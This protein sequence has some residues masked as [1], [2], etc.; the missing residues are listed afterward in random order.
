MRDVKIM[1]SKNQKKKK[2]KKKKKLAKK[3]DGQFIFSVILFRVNVP[4]NPTSGTE[5]YDSEMLKYLIKT[6]KNG[7]FA[8][9]EGDKKGMTKNL[10]YRLPDPD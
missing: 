5:V 6:I 1:S 7:I 10:Q 9:T 3:Y 8:I 2:K 4:I